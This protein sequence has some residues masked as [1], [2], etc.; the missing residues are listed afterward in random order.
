MGRHMKLKKAVISVLIFYSLSCTVFS[1]NKDQI[2]IFPLDKPTG[3]FGHLGFKITAPWMDGAI[4]MR[5]PET[6]DSEEGMH[7]IDHNRSDMQPLSKMNQ[8]PDWKMN[9]TTGEIS[10]SC[11]IPNGIEFG[12]IVN[13]TADEVHI[14]FF[15]KN[16]SDVPLSK[17]SPQF[18]LALD[19]SNDFN[20]LH[21]TSDVF[22][23][24]DGE[25]LSLDKTTP[26]AAD[27]G[28][29]PMLVIPKEGFSDMEAAGKIK[30]EKPGSD[31]G[32]WWILNQTSDEDIIMRE[33]RDKKHLVAVSWPGETSFL[34]F[35]SIIPCIHAGPTVRFTIDPQ[36]ERHWYGTVYLIQNDKNELMKRYKNGQRYN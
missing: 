5:F 27:K 15:I 31:I 16:D 6:I 22:V 29:A 32:V 10:Y 33:T 17:I 34:I 21:V 12:G 13:A 24:S 3:E 25:Y 7:F 11:T 4:E 23:W 36:R 8:F 35:N 18:C 20:Q 14:E 19:K 28:R 26:T 9:K 2:K 1:Q 30:V